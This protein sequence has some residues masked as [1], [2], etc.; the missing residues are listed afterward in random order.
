MRTTA[1][2]ALLVL[3]ILVSGSAAADA[4]ALLSYQGRLEDP[5]GELGNKQREQQAPHQHADLETD[6]ATSAFFRPF[7]YDFLI[8]GHSATPAGDRYP[9]RGLAPHRECLHR[10][11]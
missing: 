9:I 10:R 5:A 8:L 4:P 7:R 3:C 2:T 11:Q 1:L 6:L